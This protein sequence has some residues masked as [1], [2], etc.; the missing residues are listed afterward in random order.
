MTKETYACR[1]ET[2]KKRLI[3]YR[4]SEV[5]DTYGKRDICMSKRDLQKRLIGYRDTVVSDTYGK[6]DQHTSQKNLRKRWQKR[7]MYKRDLPKRPMNTKK[8]QSRLWRAEVQG[9]LPLRR[10]MGCLI[11]IRLF[12]RKSP[13]ISGSFAENDL[14]LNAF[15]S[16]PPCIRYI[17]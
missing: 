6:R 7:P 17:C 8:R 10:D 14:Q 2:Y 3:G 13:T 9:S 12:S 16:S 11:F 15:E 4:D 5:S 1:K